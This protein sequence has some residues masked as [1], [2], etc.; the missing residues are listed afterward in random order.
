MNEYK[1]FFLFLIIIILLYFI[2]KINKKEEKFD[3]TN[4]DNLIIALINKIY[5]SDIEDIRNILWKT[6][7]IS[8]EPFKIN[9]NIQVNGKLKINDKLQINNNILTTDNS[10][11]LIIIDSSSNY[12]QLNTNNINTST[13]YYVNNNLKFIGTVEFGSKFT[14]PKTTGV[15]STNIDFTLYTN[16]GLITKTGDAFKFNYPGY[17]L[18]TIGYIQNKANFNNMEFNMSLINKSTNTAAAIV[19]ASIH[20][21]FNN[22]GT[23]SS[24]G[25]TATA[26]SYINGGD[27]FEARDNYHLFEIVLN[28]TDTNI[29]YGLRADTINYVPDLRQGS[30][31]IKIEYI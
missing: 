17:Y 25:T 30:T 31:S 20:S 1:D 28:I 22:R 23:Y 19:G 16:N 9:A 6:T 24:T 4:E 3:N 14:H 27:G 10:N 29:Y 18:L 8:T 11:N 7:Q 2:Y 12:A 13:N 15:M 5:L 21:Y 26:K